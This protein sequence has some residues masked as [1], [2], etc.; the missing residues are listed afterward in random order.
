MCNH[1]NLD[2]RISVQVVANIVHGTT[3]LSNAIAQ[4]VHHAHLR[5]DLGG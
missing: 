2:S 3:G 4:V 1:H 5:P